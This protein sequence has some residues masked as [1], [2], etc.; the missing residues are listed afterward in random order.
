MALKFLF[1]QTVSYDA[2]KGTPVFA[3]FLDKSKAF[4]RT[5]YNLVFAELT[6]ALYCVVTNHFCVIRASL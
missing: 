2:N 5:N 4:D 1:R 3:A 6:F